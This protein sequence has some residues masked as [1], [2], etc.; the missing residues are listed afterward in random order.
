MRIRDHKRK[1]RLRAARFGAAQFCALF[2][3]L[4]IL[5]LLAGC[6]S[7]KR[8]ERSFFAM[9]TY[10]TLTVY[11]R[12]ESVLQSAEEK[13]REIEERLSVTKEGSEISALNRDGHAEVSRETGTLLSKA[14]EYSEMTQGAL[15]P[16][17]YPIV[18]LWGFTTGEHRVPS[19][20]EISETLPYVDWTKVRLEKNESGRESVSVPEG[21]MLDLGAVTKGYAGSVL[22]DQLLL[23]GVESA[24]L[25]LGGN[26]QTVGRKP[27]GT[28]SESAASDLQDGTLWRVAVK[29]PGG[30]G[31]LGVVQIEEMAV[32]T[33][34]AYERFFEQDGV[35]YGHIMDP[36]TGRPAETDLV[37][38]TVVHSDGV[39][40]DALSTALFVMGAEKSTAFWKSRSDFDLVLEG[41]QAF[42]H[43][44]P[45]VTFSEGRQMP[46]QAGGRPKIRD[47]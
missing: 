19:D 13:V 39:L 38:V 34:G 43:G 46:V 44:G 23:A 6:Q 10:M 31:Y 35:R 7:T 28:E 47:S 2:S 37:S 26:I 21:V 17:I 3:L 4:L 1:T 11:T 30:D 24:I 41:R 42:G 29:D 20:E 12:D 32:V 36:E 27:D 9:D 33:S 22:R 18:R 5:P 8:K 40:C 25:D 14:L 15:D 45:C 16:S